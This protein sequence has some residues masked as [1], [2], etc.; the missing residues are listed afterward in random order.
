MITELDII[1]SC[2]QVI[3]ENPVNN[4]NSNHPSAIAAL[5]VFNRVNRALQMRNWWFNHEY[6]FFLQPEIDGTIL[7]P[8]NTL[9]VSMAHVHSNFVVRGQNL[10][11]PVLHTYN[12]NRAV[13]CDITVQIDI[14]NCP[15]TFADYV[16]KQCTYEFYRNDDGDRDKT[17]DLKS[18]TQF[19]MIEARKEHMTNA[20]LNSQNRPISLP[21]MSRIFCWPTWKYRGWN[22]S[23]IARG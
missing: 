3:G 22:K 16:L 9:R 23:T 5:T 6:K 7:L 10:Y 2:L 1:N 18:E 12:I 8:I 4:A 21:M 19:A 15:D 11:D 13:E 20:R 14:E 17:L